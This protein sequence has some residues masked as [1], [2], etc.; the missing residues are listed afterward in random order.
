MKV[1]AVAEQYKNQL[2]K[3]AEVAFYGADFHHVSWTIYIF[4]YNPT[5]LHNYFSLVN[6][7]SVRV[8]VLMLK[9]SE[10]NQLRG[11]LK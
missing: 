3:V 7:F 6:L 10:I 11:E 2:R 9:L 1:N 5:S 4:L 8:P